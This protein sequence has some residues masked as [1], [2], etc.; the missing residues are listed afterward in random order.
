MVIALDALGKSLNDTSSFFSGPGL[1]DRWLKFA[2]IILVFTTFTGE[3]LGGGGGLNLGDLLEGIKAPSDSGNQPLP[4][5]ISAGTAG[6]LPNAATA[7]LA[8]SLENGFPQNPLTGLG[9]LISISDL[10]KV[11]WNALLSIII[12]AAIAL[13]VLGFILRV[14]GNAAM[15]TAFRCAQEKSV[16]FGWVKENLGKGFGLAVLQFALGLL[17]L[18]FLLM[19]AASSLVLFFK[20]IAKFPI[21]STFIPA[22][23]A[24]V[25]EFAPFMK[26]TGLVLALFAIGLL[27]LLFFAVINYFLRQFGVYL[28][29]TRDL[30]PFDSLRKS[31]SLGI[32][33][34]IE[35]LIL[36]VVQV[37][38]GLAIY[39]ATAVVGLVIAIPFAMGVI[40]LTMLGLGAGASNIFMLG[41]LTVAFIGMVVLAYVSAFIFSPIYIFIFNYNLN[42]LEGFLARSDGLGAM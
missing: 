21:F 31:I 1:F 36:V 11:D 23:Q 33:N 19:F 8:P 7:G 29:H 20:V 30:S 37:I 38:V 15:F 12:G 32:A 16:E 35:L 2:L 17:E 26:D 4:N 28:M 14:I 42:V 18:P 9:P 39:I 3:G 5:P 27:A 6:G 41:V 34:P 40:V 22:V 24:K 25:Y 13:L 10:Q